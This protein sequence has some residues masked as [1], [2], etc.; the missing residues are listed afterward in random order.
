MLTQKVQ[1][2]VKEKTRVF[3]LLQIVFNNEKSQ[4]EPAIYESLWRMLKI[5]KLN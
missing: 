5:E 2:D 3:E 1:S 4:V